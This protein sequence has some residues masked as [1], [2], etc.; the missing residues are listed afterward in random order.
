VSCIRAGG[1][2][3]AAFTAGL[4]R[5]GFAISNGYGPLK[6]ETFRIGHMGDHTE[7]GLERLLAA[8]DEVL[9]ELRCAD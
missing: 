6:G 5:R 9:S 3:V 4:G 7:E 8:A 2:D 1:L